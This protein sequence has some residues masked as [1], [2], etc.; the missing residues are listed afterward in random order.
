MHTFCR[1]KAS[2]AV[3][4]R[5]SQPEVGWLGW[6][7]AKDEQLLSALSEACGF[8]R[9]EQQQEHSQRI[10]HNSNTSNESAPP[11]PEGSH[12]EVNLVEPKVCL[13]F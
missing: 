13:I 6:R 7:N 9:G 8:D 3:I 4:A 10:R 12:E 5:C 11:S 1:H 2:G